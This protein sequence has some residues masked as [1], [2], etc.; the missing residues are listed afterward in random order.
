MGYEVEGTC[1]TFV[2][3]CSFSAEIV[4]VAEEM[5]ISDI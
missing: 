1:R 3:V 5:D 2:K 4:R